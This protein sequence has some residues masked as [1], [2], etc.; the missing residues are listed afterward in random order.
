M[1]M[2]NTTSAGPSRGLLDILFGDGKN[3]KSAEEQFDPVLALA[4]AL[5]KSQAELKMKQSEIEAIKADSEVQSQL[6][7]IQQQNANNQ[8]QPQIPI[9]G[10]QDQVPI[11]RHAQQAEI[12]KQ[13]M[14]GS[15]QVSRDSH[16]KAAS[17]LSQIQAN[18]DAINQM[19]PAD[20]AEVMK[21]IEQRM[22]QLKE[23]MPQLQKLEKAIARDGL[24]KVLAAGSVSEIVQ[25]LERGEIRTSMSTD[26]F[27]QLGMEGKNAANLK[28]ASQNTTRSNSFT[29]DGLLASAAKGIEQSAD[30]LANEDSGAELGQRGQKNFFG[31]AK[32]QNPG[33]DLSSSF[34]SEA[35][36]PLAN[37]S[38]QFG[39][40]AEPIIDLGVISTNSV[41]RAFVPEAVRAVEF[42]ATDGGG[43]MKIN[44]NPKEIGPVEL[45]VKTDAN[46]V[47]IQMM[48]ENKD[49]ADA[50]RVN[51]DQLIDS[52]KDHKIQVTNLDVSVRTTTS[53]SDSSFANNSNSNSENLGEDSSAWQDNLGRQAGNQQNDNRSFSQEYADE[54]DLGG[55]IGTRGAVAARESREERE[56]ENRP[57]PNRLIDLEV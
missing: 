30:G 6:Q 48:V 3:D 11:E 9:P 5:E 16:M 34:S 12:Q 49:L 33:A 28:N 26:E 10:G 44:L 24:D 54:L 25:K 41:R 35:I 20:R 50:I 31:E 40:I 1:D 32:I 38:S 8:I 56:T 55:D 57:D 14:S 46:K 53:S 43:E 19:N 52:L 7:A 27:L 22:S 21:M 36:S 29:E 2:S 17:I 47:Q 23:Q 15:E 37:S 51:K 13:L 39:S 4:A 18:P 42:L 45:Q